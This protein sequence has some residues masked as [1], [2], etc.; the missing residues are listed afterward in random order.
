MVVVRRVA[1]S[2]VELYPGYGSFS[3]VCV[4]GNREKVENMQFADIIS[5]VR[6][7]QRLHLS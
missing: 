2:W 5:V 6:R 4:G 1:V 3:V 7:A